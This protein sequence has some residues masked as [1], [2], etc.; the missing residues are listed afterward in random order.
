[1]DRVV[2]GAR[3]L[4]PDALVDHLAGRSSDIEAAPFIA[5]RYRRLIDDCYATASG[6]TGAAP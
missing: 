1:L 2:A 5:D 6:K 4:W 3:T